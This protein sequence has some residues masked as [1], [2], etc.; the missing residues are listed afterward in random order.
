M[1]NAKNTEKI[2]AAKSC[3]AKSE[4]SAPISVNEK[5]CSPTGFMVIKR[6]N[7]NGEKY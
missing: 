3:I 5:A 1:S 2:N 6:V 7:T 4:R